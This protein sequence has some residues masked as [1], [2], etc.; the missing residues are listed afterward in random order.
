MTAETG[1]ELLPLTAAQYGAAHQATLLD[2]YQRYVESAERVTERRSAAN[3][4]LLT[5]NTVLVSLAGL[6][7]SI[8]A[9]SFWLPLLPTAGVIVS[10]AWIG[11]LSTYR[12]LNSAKYAVIAELERQ[13]PAAPY[14]REWA[15]AQQDARRPYI[16]LARN[17]RLVPM[18][19]VAVYLGLMVASVLA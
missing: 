17:E 3:N 13:L 14:T 9:T 5:V 11:L 8:P 7:E 2:Q 16:P 10:L 15:I 12:H 6:A 18:A 4:Y 1:S 19:F